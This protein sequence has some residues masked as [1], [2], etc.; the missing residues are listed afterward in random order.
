MGESDEK[1]GTFFVQFLF[2]QLILVY[3]N[4]KSMDIT[5]KDMNTMKKKTHSPRLFQ[6]SKKRLETGE[7]IWND[8]ITKTFL[9][10]ALNTEIQETFIGFPIQFFYTGYCNIFHRINNQFETR[11]FKN[12]STE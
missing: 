2:N 8:Q 12:E 9:N 5:A 7:I 10:N 11:R 1:R 6:I 3:D 4:F